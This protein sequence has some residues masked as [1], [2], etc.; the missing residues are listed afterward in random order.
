MKNIGGL[1]VAL[2]ILTFSQ[3][4]HPHVLRQQ[5]LEAQHHVAP[6]N[7][8]AACGE[9]P[10][11]LA[12]LVGI[13]DYEHVPSLKAPAQDVADM[14]NILTKKFCF[15]AKNV[16]VIPGREADHDRII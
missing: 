8:Q 6:V 10:E 13:G 11:R 4:R 12:L 15:P 9:G 5:S 2:I 16:L 14:R 1:M 3:T 7:S